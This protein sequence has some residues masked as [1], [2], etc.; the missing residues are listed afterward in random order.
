MLILLTAC[1]RKGD[2]GIGTSGEDENGTIVQNVH[3]ETPYNSDQDDSRN[4]I[5]KAAWC[6]YWDPDTADDAD[7]YSQYSDLVIF[8]CIYSEDYKIYIPEKLDELTSKFSDGNLS[9]K[10][11][12]YI[13]FI[14]DIIHPDGS[15]TQ[16]SADFIRDVLTDG[17]LSD[18]II[19]DM[20]KQAKSIGS[21]GIELDYENIHKCDDLWDEY[22]GFV[23]ELYSRT[24]SEK[25]KL[26]VVLPVS[27]PVDEMDLPEGPQY[28]VM[29][30]NLYGNHSGPGPK[31]DEGFLKNTYNKFKSIDADYALANGGFEWGPDGKT[32]RSLTSESAKALAE[33][34][35]AGVK[36][37]DNG[38]LSYSFDS[39]EGIHT[40]YYGDEYTVDIW[41][42][43]LL[44][45]ADG[46]I[47]IDLWRLE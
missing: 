34:K 5:K 39:E 42:N 46:D 36:R 28:V 9:D 24:V 37:E 20:I 44:E 15:S 2:T 23:S 11:E 22:T 16:K 33:E 31:A 3:S 32:I 30:Y 19:D 1:G 35:G 17:E 45:N 27:T 29:C 25:M 18:M 40:V 7:K 10:H 38:A 47:G 43:M 6:V 14:N 13:S 4:I 12:I 41:S 26:R 21:D 8:G